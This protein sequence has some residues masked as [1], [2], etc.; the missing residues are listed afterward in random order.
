MVGKKKRTVYRTKRKGKP[1]SGKQKQDKT[2]SNSGQN[3]PSTSSSV[4]CSETE[5]PRV[6]ASRR[7]LNLPDSLEIPDELTGFDK[8]GYRLVDIA[9][10]SNSLSKAHV[11]DDGKYQE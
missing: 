3:Q 2:R 9:K 7:K 1:F 6:S 4:S 11:C 8:K 5:A 10:F